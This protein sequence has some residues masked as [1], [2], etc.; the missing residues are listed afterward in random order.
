[1]VRCIKPQLFITFHSYD[2]LYVRERDGRV[3]P[4][5]L[6]MASGLDREFGADHGAAL[7]ADRKVFK[8]VIV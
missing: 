3:G 7:E 8:K 1:M 5:R 6:G 2:V 4:C